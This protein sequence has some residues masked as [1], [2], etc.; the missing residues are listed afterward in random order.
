M[1]LLMDNEDPTLPVNVL[2][3]FR[4][5]GLAENVA[6]SI[7]I[8]MLLTRTYAVESDARAAAQECGHPI[9]FV[10]PGNGRTH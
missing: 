6:I 8:H 7:V 2:D 4:A 1:S 5:N 10:F 9:P 3:F